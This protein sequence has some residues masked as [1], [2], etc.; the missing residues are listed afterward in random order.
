MVSSEL[1]SVMTKR[2]LLFAEVGSNRLHK[3][4]VGVYRDDLPPLRL[5]LCRVGRGLAH[6]EEAKVIVHFGHL[7]GQLRGEEPLLL[8]L[9]RITGVELC[10]AER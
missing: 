7:G 8:G 5:H 2:D 6:V 4:R 10:C 9:G 1:V 3:L